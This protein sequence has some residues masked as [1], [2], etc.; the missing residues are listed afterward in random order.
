MTSLN[1]PSY[2]M[3]KKLLGGEDS[4]DNIFLEVNIPK[5][6]ED[7]DQ[8]FRCPIC[9]SL[10]DKAVTIKECGHTYCSVCIR[11][12]WVAIRN[13]VHR[14]EKACPICRKTVNVMDVEKALVMNRSIQEGVKAFKQMLLSHY[15]T[16]KRLLEDSP[17]PRSP[18]CRRNRKR[19]SSATR[20]Y[21]QSS[22]GDEDSRSGDEEIPIRQK[23]ESRNYARMKKKDLQRLCREFKIPTSG[24]EQELI[25]RMRNYQNMW[26]AELL[27]SIDPQNSSDIAAKLKREEQAQR[28]EKKRA[29]MTGATNSKECM[30]KLNATLRSGNQK[31]TS[32]NATFDKKLKANFEA[33]TAQI[34]SRMKKGKKLCINTVKITNIDESVD[35]SDERKKKKLSGGIEERIPMTAPS[36][37]SIEIIDVESCTDLPDSSIGFSTIDMNQKDKSLPSPS[38]FIASPKTKL[39][40]SKQSSSARHQS[41]SCSTKP[42]TT[43]PVGQRLIANMCSEN[44]K[45][46]ASP[47]SSLGTNRVGWACGRCTYVNK[48]IDYVCLIC[49]YR[50]T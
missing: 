13:G 47:A 44:K 16:S 28:N 40:S 32:G 43:E 15:R 45:K 7:L 11:N 6:F 1:R 5:D 24:S 4:E 26:N 14:Q 9:A 50:R 18:R 23:M 17:P 27:H 22:H 39:S 12:Y 37:S 25:D 33:M 21:D 46:S 31:V 3:A 20:E 48:G 10:F 41:S 8:T 2:I 36:A 38:H 49:G 34:Q 29:Q 35:M 19:M 30:R 42:H